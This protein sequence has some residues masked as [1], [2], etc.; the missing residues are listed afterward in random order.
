MNERI[1]A[2]MDGELGEDEG[3]EEILRLKKDPERRRAWERYHL[4]GDA[5]RDHLDPGVAARVSELLASEP[6]VVAPRRRK[7]GTKF[8]QFAL[9][10]AAGLAAV[11]LVAW[12]ALPMLHPESPQI[13]QLS[14]PA[15]PVAIAT[16][17]AV[18]VDSYLLAHQSFS[19]AAAM[20]GV[21]PYVRTVSNGGEERRK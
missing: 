20:Q 14:K 7:P 13:A 4:I 5:L 6:T 15:E 21:A 8:D 9:P 3:I 2:L 19:P 17:V 11:A 16:A 10:A 12:M 1:S 18:G